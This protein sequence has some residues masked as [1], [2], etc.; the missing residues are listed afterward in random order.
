MGLSEII[1]ILLLLVFCLLEVVSLELSILYQLC[2][3]LHEKVQLL[4]RSLRH[5]SMFLLQGSNILYA[6]LQLFNVCLLEYLLG[7]LLNNL[8][9]LGRFLIL[10]RQK[11][12]LI[13]P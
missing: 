4:F 10:V 6:V 9:N 8:L 1:Q 11:L 5:I 3:L 13:L 7:V 2:L 12:F